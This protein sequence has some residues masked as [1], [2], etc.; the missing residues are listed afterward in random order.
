MASKP[1]LLLVQNDLVF[2]LPY[3]ENPDQGGNPSSA[4][5]SSPYSA[6]ALVSIRVTMA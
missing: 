1:S 2:E 6:Q 3:L 5:F 4:P